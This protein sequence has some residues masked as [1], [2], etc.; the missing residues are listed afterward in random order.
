MKSLIGKRVRV[1][2]TNS[3]H[4]EGTVAKVEKNMVFL[5]EVKDT[6]LGGEQD[7]RWINTCSAELQQLVIVGEKISLKT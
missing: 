2:W 4:L 5:I 6:L 1:I 7:D 3:T